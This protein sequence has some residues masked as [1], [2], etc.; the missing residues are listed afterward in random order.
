MANDARDSGE[1]GDS[2]ERRKFMKCMA[3]AGSGVLW[4]MQGGVLRAQA[5]GA[6]ARTGT[7]SG[8]GEFSFVQLS[9]SHIGFRQA[10]NPDVT[11]TLREA[12]AKV[13]ALSV[14]PGFVVHTGDL[15]H[16]AKPG[17]FDTFAEVMGELKTD[18]RFFVPGEHDVIGDDGEQ[19]FRRFGHRGSSTRWYSFDFRGVHFIGLVNVL[20]FRP[21][22]LGA[23]GREQLEWLESDLKGL[24]SSTP[25]VVFAHMPLWTIYEKWGWG[26]EDSA[27]A[28]AYLR[29]FGSVTVLNG[30]IHQIQ[31][32]VEGNVAFYTA[33][34]TAY[35]IPVA[36]TGP[37]PGPDASVTA[38]R[39]HGLIGMRDVRYVSVNSPLAI[40]DATMDAIPAASA[41]VTIRD[42]SFRP[43]VIT[44]KVGTKVTWTNADSTPHTVTSSDKRFASSS[45]LD[46]QDRYSYVFDR[47]GTYEYF[48]S[49]HP[50]MVGKVMVEP[51]R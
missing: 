1:I 38:D 26:T 31:Q 51:A 2:I 32:K 22:G 42:F 30:H 3:W 21:G 44:V 25:V 45:G 37:A 23:L 36:G 15:T 28:L 33:R 40:T 47:A 24:S 12:V 18:Q 43:P 27:Q 41:A 6:G 11:A 10:P 34:S 39:L 49:L 19:Y 4:A 16:L 17:Q 14:A 35:P 20:N 13:N 46:T 48:C 29:R 50:M 7:Q 8:S 5:L 9:D